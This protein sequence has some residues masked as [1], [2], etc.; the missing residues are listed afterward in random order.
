MGDTMTVGFIGLGIMGKPMAKHLLNAGFNLVVHDLNRESVA[1]I[2]KEGAAEAFTPKEVAEKSEY[3]ITMLPDSADV[4]D[5]V[6]G[7]DGLLEGGSLHSIEFQTQC[8]T[9][10]WRPAHRY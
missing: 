3:L 8:E 6:F 7:R 2:V 1:A 9:L 5:V 4:E 10:G